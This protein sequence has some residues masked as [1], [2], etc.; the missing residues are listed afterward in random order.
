MPGERLDSLLRPIL[1]H[2]ID[3]YAMLKT[4]MDSRDHL[5]WALA[6]TCESPMGRALAIGARQAGWHIATD[7]HIAD[8]YDLDFQHRV[9]TL[10][11]F[12]QPRAI[13]N[14][15][16]TLHGLT[17]SLLR[18]LRDIWHDGQGYGDSSDLTAE[19]IIRYERFITA[20]IDAV[21]VLVAWQI[22]AAGQADFWRYTIG[23]MLGDMGM[24]FQNTMD[25]DPSPAAE[26]MA[27][28]NAFHQ[29]YAE[30]MRVNAIDHA[31]LESF[32]IRLQNS[33]GVHNPFGTRRL[34]PIDIERL[35]RLPG[36]ESYLRGLADDMLINPAFAGMN[37]PI[38]Q[39]HF[40]HIIRDL[41]T[42][43][44]GQVSFRD[45]D[46]ARLIFPEN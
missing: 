16:Q 39:S 35:T 42:V 12:E 10:P 5:L 9:L 18:A 21:A 28:A 17:L 15:S 7:P 38:N 13:A 23:S 1:G 14:M 11:A 2:Q 32:D 24:A 27:A 29:W 31:T 43:Q 34:K 22:R 20:D 26:R 8:G 6:W 41:D 44:V 46:L 33:N 3:P 45:P 4:V 37:D 30:P 36:M 19:D 40:M 25:G